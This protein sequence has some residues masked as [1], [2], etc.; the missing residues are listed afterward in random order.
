MLTIVPAIDIIE[1]KC[2]RLSKGDYAQKKIYNEDPLEVARQFES[3]GIQ[4]LHLVDLDG[5]KASHVI[6]WKILEKIAGQTGLIIDFGGGI[7]SNKDLKIVFECGA[8]MATIGSTAVKDR[9]LFFTWLNNYGAEKIILGADVNDRKIAVS[10]WLEVTELD[11]FSFLDDYLAQG[12][13]QVLCTD[14]SKDGMLGGTSMELYKEIIDRF[15][16]IS[17]IASGGVTSIDEIIQL[18]KLNI[19]AVIIGKA[20]YEGK[21]KLK[22]LERFVVHGL[23]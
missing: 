6:N 7:K 10:G 15:N 16:S 13:K 11:I 23:N 18:N 20:I 4:R 2:V 12:V 19:A 17:L 14:I 22:D 8:R 1:G 21:I 9:D 5:A 3:H